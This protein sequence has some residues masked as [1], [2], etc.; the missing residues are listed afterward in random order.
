MRILIAANIDTSGYGNP[1]L[2]QFARS[3]EAHADVDSVQHG[4]AWLQVEELK[5]DVVHIHWPEALVGWQPPSTQQIATIRSCLRRLSQRSVIV[6]TAHNEYPH[7]RD[8]AAFRALYAAVYAEADGIIHFGEASR[9]IIRRRYAHEISK[10]EEAVI[11]LGNCSYFPNTVPGSS[12]RKS[13]GLRQEDTVLLS[14]GRLRHTEE[15]TLLR[16][17]FELAQLPSKRLLIVARLPYSGR[18]DWRRYALR[19][20][21]WLSRSETLIERFIMPE[22]VQSYL[23]AADILIIPRKQVINSGNVALGFTF[24]RVVV[25]PSTGVVGEILEQTANPTFD[26]EDS[27]SLA[28]AMEKGYRLS[29]CGVGEANKVIASQAMNWT[30]IAEQHARFYACL[31]SHKELSSV[32]GPKRPLSH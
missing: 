21:L 31:R 4:T 10:A 6:V 14:F 9:D 19:F 24:G 7:Y 11:P 27:R 28:E 18:G 8:T 25:G 2:F 12:A 17:A 15:L 1:F 26:P 32:A 29:R 22:Y 30:R 23:N 16:R 5:T 3:L 20:P 13:L